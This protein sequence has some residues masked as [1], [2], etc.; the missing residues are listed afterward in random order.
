METTPAASARRQPTLGDRLE[1]VSRSIEAMNLRIRI[2]I[3]ALVAAR[4]GLHPLRQPQLD[5]PRYCTTWIC[6]LAQSS[7]ISR[8]WL[9]S[10]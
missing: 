2:R 1:A 6:R 10:W 9:T 7:S 5:H 4:D 3:S 8:A